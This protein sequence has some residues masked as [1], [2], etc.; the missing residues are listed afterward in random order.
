[1]LWITIPQWPIDIPTFDYDEQPYNCRLDS[2]QTVKDKYILEYVIRTKSKRVYIVL[3][4]LITKDD[5]NTIYWDN[6]A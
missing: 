2:E 4:L 3:D 5:K 6:S 1:M